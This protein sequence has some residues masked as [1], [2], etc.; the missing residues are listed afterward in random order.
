M[1]ANLGIVQSARLQNR[2]LR[3]RVDLQIRLRIGHGV[4]VTRLAGQIEE[5]VLAFHEVREAVR[6]A[7]I[8]DVQMRRR[9][10]PREIVQIATVFRDQ[11][12]HQGD[13]RAQPDQP[14]R[15]MRTDEA[16]P[17]GN[18]HAPARKRFP[19]RHC[20]AG[21][22]WNSRPPKATPKNRRAAEILRLGKSLRPPAARSSWGFVNGSSQ[23][24]FSALVTH[25]WPG[26]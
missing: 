18:E 24:C 10:E 3:P 6:I 1:L 21:R 20:H 11:A 8:R 7:H 23:R 22:M 13:F 15:Q 14:P 9:P 4:Q 19:E 12:V 26:G 5:K 25:P 17:A 2:E 16:R